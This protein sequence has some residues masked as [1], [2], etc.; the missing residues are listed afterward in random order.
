VR[1]SFDRVAGI[2]VWIV[3]CATVGATSIWEKPFKTW[4]DAEL[5][6]FLATSPWTGKA[7]VS[8]TKARGAE[9]QPIDET[10]HVTWASA[11]P[12]RQARIRES[13]GVGGTVPPDAEQSVAQPLPMY[14]IT[15]KVSGGPASSSYARLVTAIQKETF[16][17]REG[18]EPIAAMQAEGAVLDKNGNVIETPPGPPAPGGQGAGGAPQGALPGTGPAFSLLRTADQGQ[19]GGGGGG[20]GGGGF[21]GR[22]GV[23]GGSSRLV[24]AFPKSDPISLTDKEVELVTK[25]G[26][27]TVKKK[28]RLKEM[29][30]GGEPAL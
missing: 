24:F 3:L 21:G 17:L 29:V 23:P 25:V 8:Y 22:G 5:K 28:F 4:S 14:V 1:R 18:K 26:Q 16:L 7:S 9:S 11:L 12:V 27:Y 2:G 15:L 13:I 20:F 30:I 6:E 19:R 10:I